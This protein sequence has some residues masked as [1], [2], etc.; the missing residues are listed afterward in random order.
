MTSKLLGPI[1]KHLSEALATA[2]KTGDIK[3]ESR[4]KRQIA[5]KLA[6]P[7]KLN[8]DL[9][10]LEKI[11]EGKLSAVPET[12][13]IS[14]INLA[15]KMEA[16]SL[17]ENSLTNG[18]KGWDP[19]LIKHV[20]ENDFRES[21]ETVQ[22][23]IDYDPALGKYVKDNPTEP[24]QS[25]MAGQQ[26]FD[27]PIIIGSDGLVKD[28]YKRINAMAKAGLNDSKIKVMSAEAT[29]FPSVALAPSVD[30]VVLNRM[31]GFVTNLEKLV[32]S[33]E[34]TMMQ[35]QKKTMASTAFPPRERMGSAAIL[36]K[37]TT[38]NNG[39]SVNDD[40]LMTGFAVDV[41]KVLKDN[42]GGKTGGKVFMTGD[43]QYLAP[44]NMNKLQEEIGDA[45]E[46]RILAKIESIKG[47]PE[48]L[49]PKMTREDKRSLAA[50]LIQVAR[51]NFGT[52]N[53]PYDRMALAK[54]RGGA[55]GTFKLN[56]T[57][58]SLPLSRSNVNDIARPSLIE[59][60]MVW[61]KDDKGVGKRQLL[62]TTSE[63]YNDWY[64]TPSLKKGIKGNHGKRWIDIF[65]GPLDMSLPS[66]IAHGKWKVIDGK[67]VKA[68]LGLRA[69]DF[70]AG[71]D[72]SKYSESMFDPEVLNVLNKTAIGVDKTLY[73]A[74]AF[75]S[76]KGFF[77][78]SGMTSKQF[79]N[80]LE[81]SGLTTDEM[82]LVTNYFK[83]IA[84]LKQEFIRE[85][86]I[87]RGKEGVAL[88]SKEEQLNVFKPKKNKVR[89]ELTEQYKEKAGEARGGDKG[90]GVD[91][92]LNDLLK[93][94]EGQIIKKDVQQSQRAIRGR[95]IR[96]IERRF[97][98]QNDGEVH[99][100]FKFDYR[101]RVYSIDPSGANV[102]TGGF[103]R[104]MFRFSKEMG[105]D[106]T[107]GDAAFL[108]IVDDLVLFEDF[109]MGGAKIGKSESTGLQRHAYW[110][111]NEKDYLKRASEIL[112]VFEK[113]AKDEDF[114]KNYQSR[115]SWMKNRGDAGPY[116]SALLEIGRIKRAY[117]GV[118]PTKLGEQGEMFS[119]GFKGK[120]G[121]NDDP[122]GTFISQG[123]RENSPIEGVDEIGPIGPKEIYGMGDPMQTPAPNLRSYR[124][125][126]ALEFDAPQ[127]G[128]QHINAQYGQI[129]GLIK[130]SVFTESE[131]VKRLL[132][133]DEL[134]DLHAGVAPESVAPDLYRDISIDYD[135]FWKAYIKDLKLTDPAKA[136]AYDVADKAMMKS[137]RGV[138]KPLVM[139]VPYG[140]GMARLKAEMFEQLT[141]R[142][143]LQLKEQGIDPKDFMDVHW[144]AMN[145]A[146]ETGLKTQFEFREWMRGF[147]DIYKNAPAIDS[148]KRKRL[149][150]KSPFGGISDFTVFAT[151]AEVLSGTIRG[152]RVPDIKAPIR[153]KTKGR[154]LRKDGTR[155]P[156]QYTYKADDSRYYNTELT[157]MGPN[158]PKTRELLEADI[159]AGKVAKD[160]DLQA[161]DGK[162]LK[163][164]AL[165]G[166]ND[167]YGGLAPN[168][169][170]NIDAGFLQKLVIE[171]D[172]IGIPVM[173]VH[174]AFFI[175]P[176]DID[177]FRQLAGTTFQDMHNGYNLRKEMIDSLSDAT[178]LSQDVI[179]KRIEAHLKDKMP[180]ADDAIEGFRSGYYIDRSNIDVPAEQGGKIG[181]KDLFTPYGVDSSYKGI[182]SPSGEGVSMDNVIRG[183]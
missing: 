45:V 38:L 75:F 117:D 20:K 108:R 115:A 150:V 6:N 47:D 181:P 160:L 176:T 112:E 126:F 93:I 139:K 156:Q 90:T 127:S 105:V 157:A 54:E 168:A 8:R 135:K 162:M 83:D 71:R 37:A 30:N 180:T 35:V 15:N 91:N 132:T 159:E 10:T 171:A 63:Y 49:V 55:K 103:V 155:G 167:M 175:R 14:G 98:L 164:F 120:A 80:D 22:D 125:T 86:N 44:K 60:K 72:K 16:N 110:K 148:I 95:L 121:P 122:R 53:A 114:F 154:K 66:V 137:G 23:L 4:V 56:K 18:G 26:V 130:T 7:K 101:G 2:M 21:T 124:S 178:G 173:V 163:E 119:Q 69:E 141:A 9:E 82:G 166:E 52:N 92:V 48:D 100:A 68:P 36:K 32:N 109:P 34:N 153:R 88:L 140:A 174:D 172:K 85:E 99:T 11:Q 129:E 64:R 31:G 111:Q 24:P 57:E 29:N 1:I 158:D 40:L 106:I 145:N 96:E 161:V 128:S 17:N 42:T 79:A 87:L 43:Q 81:K 84:N 182:T 41:L 61:T 142:N 97:N 138:T 118:Q 179:I 143:R 77:R 5:K 165:G 134:A 70:L 51:G 67:V 76:G 46:R 65:E 94:Y 78:D 59:E 123:F 149:K 13:P 151:S 73:K 144:D 28:G 169:T 25:A 107:Y 116:I 74:W 131:G 58:Q 50:G 152:N 62:L 136:E 104:H 19:E 170:H 3:E 183:G 27:E 33:T 147:G 89:K 39:E 177:A 113:G 12:K 146:L 102:Q 133:T